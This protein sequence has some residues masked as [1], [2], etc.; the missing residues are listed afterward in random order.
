MMS[1]LTDHQLADLR[2]AAGY[3][4]AA[5]KQTSEVD[6]A[7]LHGLLSE[8]EALRVRCSNSEAAMLRMRSRLAAR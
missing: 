4:L 8:V 5:G 2:M 3:D 7:A 1:T 6:T